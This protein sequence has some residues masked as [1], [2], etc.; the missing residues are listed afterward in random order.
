MTRMII[1]DDTEITK[2]VIMNQKQHILN[3]PPHDL[4]GVEE[5]E[6]QKDIQNFKSKLYFT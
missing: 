6:R 2:S 1:D 5:V 3:A 4:Q